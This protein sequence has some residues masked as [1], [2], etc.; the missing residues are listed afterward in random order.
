MEDYG[1]YVNVPKLF[2]SLLEILP[3]LMK[4]LMAE[5]RYNKQA[6]VL[7]GLSAYLLV[8]QGEEEELSSEVMRELELMCTVNAT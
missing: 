6:T 7:G 4:S 1:D 3:R 8:I 5:R 2:D